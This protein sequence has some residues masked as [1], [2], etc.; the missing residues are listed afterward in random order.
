MEGD[1]IYILG[2]GNYDELQGLF[3]L[4][5]EI[6]GMNIR[7]IPYDSQ[8]YQSIKGRTDLLIEEFKGY[9]AKTAE[10]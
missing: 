4:Y 6:S 10:S 9:F 5:K 2:E 3:N 8:E 1:R 7:L